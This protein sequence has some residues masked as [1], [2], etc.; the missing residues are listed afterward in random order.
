MEAHFD[1]RP[2]TIRHI[3]KVRDNLHVIIDDLL[4]RARNHDHSKL[5]SPEVEVFDEYTPKL[6]YLT[7]GSPEYKEAL[8]GMGPALAHHY[9]ACDHHPE[10]FENGIED[11]SLIQ[12]IE[13]LC[14]WKAAV[15]RHADGDIQKSIDLN[16][17]RF[18]YGDE[19]RRL[20]HNTIDHMEKLS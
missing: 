15:E 8:A 2:D 19:V 6:K 4:D 13:M 14:D 10:H 20:L 16:A 5:E 9:A 18:G 17:E 12:I 3:Q 1:S 11:M 7:Y